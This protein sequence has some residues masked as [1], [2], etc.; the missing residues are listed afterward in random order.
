MKILVNKQKCPQN[1]VCP[2]IKVCP[3]GAISQETPFSLPVV[4]AE[5]C[6][7]CG[8][9]MQFCPMGAFEKVE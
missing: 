8:K 6:I 3:K 4:D 2:S 5:K 1:H 9:C 7:V